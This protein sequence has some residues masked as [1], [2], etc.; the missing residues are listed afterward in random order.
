MGDGGWIIE[1]LEL[2]VTGATAAAQW[3]TPPGLLIALL[4][5]LRL[6]NGL[7]LTATERRGY[8]YGTAPLTD[9]LGL[10]STV[11]VSH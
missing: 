3:E 9:A 5:P 7:S 10:L 11:C 6:S 4:Q 2:N 1:G 8:S